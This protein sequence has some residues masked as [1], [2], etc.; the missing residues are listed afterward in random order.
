MPRFITMSNIERRRKKRRLN[1]IIFIALA[2]LAVGGIAAL[3]ILLAG[4]SCSSAPGQDAAVTEAPP[5]AELPEVTDTPSE[6]DPPAPTAQPEPSGDPV[7]ISDEQS[8]AMLTLSCAP[9]YDS[10]GRFRGA[11]SGSMAVSFLNNTDRTLYSASFN[12][13]SAQV[14]F[15]SAEGAPVRFTLENGVL[16]V[17]FVNELPVNGSVD[18]YFSFETSADGD[19]ILAVPSIAYDTS[20]TLTA[21]V[22]SRVKLAFSGC[23]AESAGDGEELSYTVPEQSV[24]EICISFIH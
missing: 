20:F 7:R 11:A 23:D 5:A 21:F 4:K 6:T 12:V 16:T 1:L 17:P 8:A 18:I 22:T 24:R 14:D 3:V 13:G 19:G 9:G 10:Q 2:V 15:A